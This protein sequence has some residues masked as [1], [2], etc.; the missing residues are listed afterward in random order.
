MA[1]GILADI[2]VEF[3]TSEFSYNP[4]TGEFKRLKARGKWKANEIAGSVSKSTGYITLSIRKKL[5]LAH[6]LAWLYMY[7]AWPLHTIDHINGC[8]TDNRISNLRDVE[9]CEN[10]RNRG[11]QSNNTSGASGVTWKKDCNRWYARAF[12]NGREIQLGRFHSRLDAINARKAW[13]TNNP[14]ESVQMRHDN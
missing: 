8:K 9:H 12:K 6:R 1:K 2:T 4:D 5:Y 10:M 7:G 13:E 3:L 11:A 14:I